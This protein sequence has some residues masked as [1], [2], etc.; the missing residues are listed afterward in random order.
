[1]NH[2]QMTLNIV[3]YVISG[4]SLVILPLVTGTLP[5][6]DTSLSVLINEEDIVV[7]WLLPDAL[8]DICWP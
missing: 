8:C 2:L 5:N 1:M 4:T 6:G 7:R 3:G